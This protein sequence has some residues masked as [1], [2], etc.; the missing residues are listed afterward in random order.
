MKTKKESSATAYIVAIVTGMFLAVLWLLS[1]NGIEIPKT[2]A[3]IFL[4]VVGI[5]LLIWF[6]M[7]LLSL[8]QMYHYNR[9]KYDGETYKE[10]CARKFNRYV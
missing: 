4:I 1:L 7:F 3:I 6:I 2:L 9:E 5:A 10:F 8:E